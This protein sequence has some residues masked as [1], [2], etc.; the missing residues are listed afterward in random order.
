[1]VS[2]AQPE[3]EPV[4]PAREY[5]MNVVLTGELA[6]RVRDLAATREED[7]SFASMVEKILWKFFDQASKPQSPSVADGNIARKAKSA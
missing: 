4:E 6:E 3:A 2:K 7:R 5:R 1:M